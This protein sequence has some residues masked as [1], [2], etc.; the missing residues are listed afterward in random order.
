M[1]KNEDIYKV[2]NNQLK[3]P[4]DP[5]LDF[6]HKVCGI[7]FTSKEIKITK[8]QNLSRERFFH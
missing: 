8:T 2:I 4:G 1:N 5:N 7:Y 3:Q 6:Q